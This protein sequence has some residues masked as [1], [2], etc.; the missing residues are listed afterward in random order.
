LNETMYAQFPDIQMIAE[1]STSFTGVSRPIYT[2]GL[3]FGQKWM[4]GWMNDT[5]KYFEKDP[6]HRKYHQDQLTFSTNYAFTE[7]FMLPFSHDEVVYGKHSL[8]GKMPGDDWQK[9]ANLRLLFAYMFTH[10]GTNLLFMGGEFGQTA[11]WDFEKGLDWW[12]LEHAPHKGVQTLIKSLNNLY[13]TEAALYDKQ[14]SHEGFEW[15]DTTD[16]ENSI[17]VYTRKGNIA[18]DQLIILLNLTPIPRPD[19][20]I[21]VPMQGI[22][23]EVLNTDDTA[24]WGSGK[25][26]KS[27]IMADE[28][29]WHGKAYSIALTIP[30][31]GAVIL[32]VK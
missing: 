3:G 10:P 24:F 28:I 2:G 18:K 17:V 6:M 23:Q 27:A 14:F 29:T 22:W 5:L 26:N 7:N 15:L 32:K 1:E 16:R 11:E 30:P 8:V 21:G 31:L 12:L 20:R 13:K 19:Y 4:M 25:V 9:F